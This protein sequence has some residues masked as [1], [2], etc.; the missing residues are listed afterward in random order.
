MTLKFLNQRVFT[1]AT[2]PKEFIVWIWSHLGPVPI[3]HW[4]K[5]NYWHW[6]SSLCWWNC[7]GS[8][9]CN[10]HSVWNRATW[11]Q[12]FLSRVPH[13]MQWNHYNYRDL[14]TISCGPAQN[15]IRITFLP[16]KRKRIPRRWEQHRIEIKGTEWREHYHYFAESAD[17]RSHLLGVPSQSKCFRTWFAS[18]RSL[19][20]VEHPHLEQS[21]LNDGKYC[22]W[23]AFELHS[24]THYQLNDMVLIC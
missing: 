14:E 18:I 10:R 3:L 16:C 13:E 4:S 11:L 5:P 15:S 23:F 1:R 21:W 12:A 19:F 8:L 17:N 7:I 6:L 2:A 9:P 22:K 20:F 24:F